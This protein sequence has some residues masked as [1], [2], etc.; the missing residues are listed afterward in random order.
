M[1]NTVPNT[2]VIVLVK[3]N[4]LFCIFDFSI[5]KTTTKTLEN[6]QQSRLD[7]H[8]SLVSGLR[9]SPKRDGW[10]CERQSMSVT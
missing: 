1:Y 6:G 10:T 8:R 4:N 2:Q 7:F 3:T 5:P 9:S